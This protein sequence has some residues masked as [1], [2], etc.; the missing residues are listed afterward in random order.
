MQDLHE[1]GGNKSFINFCFLVDK[2]NKIH[3]ETQ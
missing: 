2:A 1:N 3:Y